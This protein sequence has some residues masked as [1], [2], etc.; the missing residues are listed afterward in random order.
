MRYPLNC[1][2][3]T[4]AVSVVISR[5]YGVV[6]WEILTLGAQPY[7]GRSNE[8]VLLGVIAGQ[9]MDLTAFESSPRVL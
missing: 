8:E 3:E 1:S 5:S 9:V 7:P 4:N 2:Q 6:L